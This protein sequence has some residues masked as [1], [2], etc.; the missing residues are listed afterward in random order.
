MGISEQEQY[1]SHYQTLFFFFFALWN[2]AILTAV[3]LAMLNS[4]S[5]VKPVLQVTTTSPRSLLV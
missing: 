5:V 1:P 3:S 4:S 2:F